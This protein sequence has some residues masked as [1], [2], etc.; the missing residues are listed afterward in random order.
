M[1]CICS[2]SHICTSSSWRVTARVLPKLT[3]WLIF[4]AFSKRVLL[5]K[6]AKSLLVP[7]LFDIPD[8]IIM[9]EIELKVLSISIKSTSDLLLILSRNSVDCFLI[10]A[11]VHKILINYSIFVICFCHLSA[12]PA[13]IIHSSND[14][15]N[16]YNSYHDILDRNIIWV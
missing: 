8:A 9:H 16:T 6:E 10:T 13:L 1:Q 15:S 2:R 3:K 12:P 14:I 4:I 7:N 11:C 5:L